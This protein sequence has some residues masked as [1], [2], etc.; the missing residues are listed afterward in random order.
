MREISINSPAKINLYLRV[1]DKRDDG[2]HNIDTSFQYVDIYDYMNF[3]HIES[4]IKINSEES[5][6]SYKDNTIYKSAK[7]LQGF[8]KKASGVEISIKKIFL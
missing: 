8:S 7:I 3:K 6:L 2:Y 1:K 5:Y 4:G